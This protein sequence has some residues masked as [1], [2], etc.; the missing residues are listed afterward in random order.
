[1]MRSVPTRAA[2]LRRSGG[3]ASPGP[4]RRTSGLGRVSAARTTRVLI[5]EDNAGVRGGLAR[6]LERSGYYVQTVENGLAALAVVEG[7]RFDVVVCDVQLPFLDGMSFY[8]QL[9]DGHPEIARRTIFITAW[10]HEPQV[11][12]FLDHVDRPYLEKPFRMS[13]MLNLIDRVALDR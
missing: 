10:V 13:E 2:C 11:R 8:D 3:D 9:I 12:M 4:A 7:D 6:F 1:M 5:V